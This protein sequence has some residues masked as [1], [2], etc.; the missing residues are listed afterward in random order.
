[1]PIILPSAIRVSDTQKE[2]SQHLNRICK[3]FV[4]E[5]TLN[6]G[7]EEIVIMRS[8]DQVVQM[9]GIK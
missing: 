1:M 7:P 3:G 9:G 8:G 6:I 5:V 2:E 4:A